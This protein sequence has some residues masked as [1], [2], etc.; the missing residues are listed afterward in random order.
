VDKKECKRCGW[1]CLAYS[2]TLQAKKSDIDRW[3]N[4]YRVDIL[5]RGDFKIGDWQWGDL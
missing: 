3:I 2:G 5:T 1:C 4:E